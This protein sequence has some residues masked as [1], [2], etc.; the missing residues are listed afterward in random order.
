MKFSLRRTLISALVGIALCGTA[1]HA[2]VQSTPAVGQYQAKP[3]SV[4]IMVLAGYSGAQGGFNVEWM[5]KSTF[6]ALGGWPA[7][8]DPALM[9]GEFTGT[10][11]WVTEGTSG[12]YTLPPIK[13][14]ALELGQLFDESGVD[15]TST[16]ELEANTEY[17]VRVSARASG[18]N[19][20]SAMSPT[21]IVVT[22]AAPRNCTFT[23][24]YWKNH[25]DVWPV[26]SLTLGTVNYNAAELLAIFNQ[27]AKGNGLTILAHQLIAA[28]LNIAG[29]ADPSAAAAA[30]A[31]A[32]AMIGNL[33]CVPVGSGTL[34]PA[35][36]NATAQ[37]LDSYNNGLI[38]PGHCGAVPATMTTWGS[39]KSVYRK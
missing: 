34:S 14:Q 16:D 4:R 26:G 19:T 11:V 38:G 37:T 33:V 39:V 36:V 3:T 8:G 17:V 15:A 2:G 35:S 21:V 27:P 6:D 20:E 24:G 9:R 18:T 12:D 10:P 5:R 30:I 23:Q 29:G 13:W 31:A 32:D 22:G 7:T 1:A 25:E 28:K